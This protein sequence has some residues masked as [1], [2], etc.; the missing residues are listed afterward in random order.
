MLINVSN[1]HTPKENLAIL[2]FSLFF[3]SASV[4]P[5][6]LRSDSKLM[7]FGLADRSINLNSY[8]ANSAIFNH[9]VIDFSLT[10]SYALSFIGLDLILQN[11]F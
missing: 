5:L 7:Y 9:L 8:D 6:F 2:V 10:E 3:I 1:Q 4:F 11:H